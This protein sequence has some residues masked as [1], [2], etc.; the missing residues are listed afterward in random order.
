[1]DF[2][3]K[4]MDREEG[5][6]IKRLRGFGLSPVVCPGHDIVKL[7]ECIEAVKASPEEKPKVIAAKT[8]KGFGLKCMEN[9]PKF[10][11][12]VPSEEDLKMGKTY[13]SEF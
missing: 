13:E 12:R 4:I 6:L 10:H 5:G 9:V 11:F 1:M 7:V 2:L 8:I 3:T